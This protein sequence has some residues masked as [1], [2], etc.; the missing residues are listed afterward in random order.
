MKPYVITILD[1]DNSV[2]SSE[3][4]IRSAKRVGVKVEKWEAVTPRSENFKELQETYKIDPNRFVSK[5]SRSENAIA[6]FLSHVS[7]WKECV[8]KDED[9][10]ILEH[11]AI[12]IGRI[13][14]NFHFDRIVS[15]GKPSYGKYNVPVGLSGLG[16][17]PLQHAPYL[18]GA[19]AYVVSPVG[20]KDLLDNIEKHC[21]P[22]D[23]Y[24]NKNLFPYLEEYYPWP[25]VVRDSYSTIQK[26]SGCFA[27]H[28]VVNGKNMELIEP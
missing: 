13:P 8:E 3:R 15:I 22:T 20:A 27:K 4:C 21:Q 1:N 16:T 5:W 11:D 23:I 17:I 19:H 6:C 10:L 24:L 7:L 26:E 28:T 18:K 25:V 9:I 12:F 14:W 2:G